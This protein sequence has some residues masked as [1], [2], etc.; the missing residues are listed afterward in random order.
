M[1]MNIAHSKSQ[2]I[3]KTNMNLHAHVIKYDHHISEAIDIAQQCLTKSNVILV[4]DN[5]QLQRSIQNILNNNISSRIPKIFVEFV[6]ESSFIL[7]SNDPVKSLEMISKNQYC[8]YNVS[9]YKKV[10]EVQNIILNIKDEYKFTHKTYH[11]IDEYISLH[12]QFCSKLIHDQYIS[13]IDI[14]F[15]Y[16]HHYLQYDHIEQCCSYIEY[17]N[18]LSVYYKKILSAFNIK[19]DALLIQYYHIQAIKLIEVENIQSHNEYSILIQSAIINYMYIK[20][21]LLHNIDTRQI[22]YMSMHQYMHLKHNTDTLMNALHVWFYGLTL[23]NKNAIQ[24]IYCASDNNTQVQYTYSSHEDYIDT[25][26][27]ALDIP[28]YTKLSINQTHNIICK[29]ISPNPPTEYR[30]KEF[31]INHITKL[32][33]NPYHFYIECILG[34]KQII[35]HQNHAVGVLIHLLVEHCIQHYNAILSVRDAYDAMKKELDQYQH[36]NIQKAI[37]ESKLDGIAHIVWNIINNSS[38][39]Y[40]EREA[41]QKIHYADRE[42]I[43]YGRADLIYKNKNNQYGIFD[44][45]TGYVPSWIELTNGT[46]PQIALGLLILHCGGFTDDVNIP[47]SNICDSGFI[48]PKKTMILDNIEALIESSKYGI[49]GLIDHFWMHRNPYVYIPNNNMLHKCIA[50]FYET[51]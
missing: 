30:K 31:A 6:L 20:Y 22:T 48:S 46:A 36:T 42:Y 38:E 19:Y 51:Y 16:I 21:H 43:L 33:N 11:N 37:I 5:I 29:Y 40:A 28:K 27:N 34:L 18:H 13:I 3:P 24:E 15:Q 23:A 4:T 8:K 9:R 26:L 14:V 17:L 10:Y 12:K 25:I 39:I 32:V 49:V 2:E 44:F 45:K 1:N 7:Y 47:I 50:R 35:Y 41:V